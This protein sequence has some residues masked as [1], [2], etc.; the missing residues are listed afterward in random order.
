[1]P[2]GET[3]SAIANPL[4]VVSVHLLDL[5]PRLLL[6]SITVWVIVSVA[7]PVCLIFVDLSSGRP[8]VPTLW[9]PSG[10]CN[11]YDFR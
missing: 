4:F 1:M 7:Q 2:P 6:F 9:F 10:R 8:L 11:L 3:G 5:A